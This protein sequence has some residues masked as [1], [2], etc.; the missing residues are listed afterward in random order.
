VSDYA[1]FKARH[2]ERTSPKFQRDPERMA[3]A[4]R[5]RFSQK[6]QD[7]DDDEPLGA[8]IVKTE[9]IKELVQDIENYSPAQRELIQAG[10]YLAL[11]HLTPWLVQRFVAALATDPLAAQTADAVSESLQFMGPPQTVWRE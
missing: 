9:A 5:H 8:R 2:P 6:L 10:A 11:S 7:H 4:D 1:R 3:E